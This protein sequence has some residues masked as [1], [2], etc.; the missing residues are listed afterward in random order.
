M[1]FG[2]VSNLQ[3]P[4]FPS[5][6]GP[7][8]AMS[9]PMPPDFIGNGFGSGGPP[10]HPP[11]MM[12]KP[13]GYGMAPPPFGGFGFDNRPLG[14]PP[15]TGF[16]P[17]HLQGMFNEKQAL[18]LSN[19]L[20]D[21]AL[22]NTA[23][24]AAAKSKLAAFA[25][26]AATKILAGSLA[27]AEQVNATDES[28]NTLKA[29]RSQVANEQ[30]S[31]LTLL[32]SVNSTPRPSIVELAV[33]SSQALPFAASPSASGAK[34]L[35]QRVETDDATAALA[36]SSRQDTLLTLHRVP[37]LG[38]DDEDTAE[39][40]TDAPYLRTSHPAACSDSDIDITGNDNS[41]SKDNSP[42][43]IVTHVANLTR[44]SGYLTKSVAQI[45]DHLDHSEWQ[46]DHYEWYIACLQLNRRPEIIASESRITQC[47]HQMLAHSYL[48]WTWQRLR[49]EQVWRWYV[50]V[51]DVPDWNAATL[52]LDLQLVKTNA[53]E[54]LKDITVLGRDYKQFEAWV[55]YRKSQTMG[56][57]YHQSYA[58]FMLELIG[59]VVQIEDVPRRFKHLARIYRDM[60]MEC[61]EDF[62]PIQEHVIVP[63]IK[64]C[65]DHIH[66][67]N[68]VPEWNLLFH[69]IFH[70]Y[71]LRKY[72]DD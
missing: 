44:G 64:Q 28:S 18:Y 4:Y 10:L 69:R 60:E 58:P 55:V 70:I 17:P 31:A 40:I 37:G 26:G 56:R 51:L 43:G 19:G 67:M 36:A 27:G 66:L 47:V 7:P 62:F 68:K 5:F 20:S 2:M 25:G 46:P 72:F 13:M 9:Q 54:L 24:E 22:S 8:G 33:S 59:L 42:N 48:K 11:H 63:L 34:S 71:A 32:P 52:P 49:F 45:L 29:H 3:P 65:W 38:T 61:H 12:D 15:S 6:G 39:D 14:P 53:L 23:K 1:P 41:K 21:D 30:G 16:I 50:R 35:S 57:R